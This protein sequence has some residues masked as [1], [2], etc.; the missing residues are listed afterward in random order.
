MAKNQLIII[1]DLHIERWRKAKKQLF[2]EFLD[3]VAAEAGGLFMIL[4]NITRS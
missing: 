4:L 3:F 1:S 2:F